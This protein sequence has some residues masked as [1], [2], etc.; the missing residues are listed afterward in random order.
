M[1]GSGVAHSFGV[2]GPLQVLRDGE[3]VP[4]A[5]RRER[6]LLAQFLL[7]A[8]EVVSRERLVDG[9]W[10][11]DP[12]ETAA[13]ALQVA[14]H[15]L[16]KA[17]GR[18]RIATRG[19]GYVLNVAPGE[20]DL[21]VFED[22]VAAA[23]VAEPG[24]AAE[25]LTSALALWRGEP[26]ADV[27]YAAFAP[28]EAARLEE[29]RLAAF[30]ERIEL[31]LE[32]GAGG[33]LVGEL[34][35]LVAA[36]PYREGLRRRLMLALYRAG[37]QAEALDVYRA[38]RRVLVD[39]LGVEPSPELQELERAI[40]RQDPALRPAAATS[41]PGARLPTPATALVGRGLE[42]SSVA[43]LLREERVRL[44]TLT[45]PGGTGKTR[46]ALEVATELGSAL[47]DGAVF[48]DLSPVQEPAL[49]VS[50]IASALA[51]GDT[52]E[53]PLADGIKETLRARE[54][55]LVVDNFEHV[56]AAAPLL[57]ELLAVAPGVQALVTSRVLL[58][59]SGEHDFPVPPLPLPSASSD[60]DLEELS[61]NEAVA[62]FVARA[63]AARP[64]FRLTEQNGSAVAELCVALDGLPLALEL[65]AARA[66]VLAP[67][68]IL[69][70][71]EA[72]LDLL[73][74]GGRD[75]P[76]RQQ[77][78]RA[79][80]DW[81]HGLLDEAAAR[82]FARLSVF[83]GSCSLVAAEAVCAGD[84]D[85]I[86]QLVESSLVARE[87]S[88]QGE[89][90]LRLLETVRAYALER[91][92]AEGEVTEL[93]RRHAEHFAALAVT[94]DEEL[95]AG[96]NQATVYARLEA[97]HDNLRAAL[98]WLAEAGEAELELRLAR[99]LVDF[100]RVRGF[101][102]EGSRRLEEALERGIDLAP[103]LLAEGRV[104]AASLAFA[105][106]DWKRVRELRELNLSVYRELGDDL[107]VARMQHELASSYLMD[108]DHQQ[109][110]RFYDDSIEY[111]RAADD[112][113]RL[114]IALA[115]R[116][117]T[118][119]AAGDFVAC[120]ELGEE[121][122]AHQA[123]W[124]DSESTAIT[125][126]TLARAA[127]R[128]GEVE[129]ARDGLVRA[130]RLA[131]E[132]GHREVLAYCLEGFAELDCDGDPERSAVLLGAAEALLE[133]VG[134]AVQGHQREA[135]ESVAAELAARLGEDMMEAL[136]VEGRALPP[137]EATALATTER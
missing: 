87:D 12:P 131:V 76:A 44:L 100:W 8:N 25:R 24:E 69:K 58:R 84:L 6:A 97:E 15:G 127:F 65:A 112:T 102:G 123:R 45:G 35:G 1:T 135:F 75:L 129:E 34:E 64:D 126:Q 116:A 124:D 73:T 94:A 117:E 106:G 122:L 128:A 81:S 99:A 89:L 43:A 88:R 57:S 29:R 98:A 53:Q 33:E 51:V 96:G 16:R 37:R 101:A 27:G 71:L 132:I 121:A 120:R 39:E 109:A 91:L 92:E 61:R 60:P 41:F 13:N 32:L 49:V 93:R 111:F 17:L 19:N 114:G 107:N 55:L 105:L 90:R 22:H 82:L 21:D 2:L 31:E 83:A 56:T 68:G 67:E 30:E 3:P 36:H 79:T 23:R 110:G 80:L 137:E 18:E 28:A 14:V 5:G 133:H 54:L 134:A 40:L 95:W 115:N 52:P 78:L 70:R 74:T 11:E 77:T 59:V 10:G 72:R 113:M 7:R 26:L 136:R 46:I 66:N 50:V 130:S 119:F 125:L 104:G 38:A 86:S 63:R 20:L 47:R 62:L 4:L 42:I 48:V 108:G 103:E 118:A 85:E 9:L